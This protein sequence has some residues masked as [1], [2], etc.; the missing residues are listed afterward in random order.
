MTPKPKGFFSLPRELRDEIYD[1]LHRHELEVKLE[2]VALRF[3]HSPA[4]LRRISRRFATECALRIPATGPTHLTVSLTHRIREAYFDSDPQPNRL[5]TIAT[6]RQDALFRELEFEVDV[7][8]CYEPYYGEIPRIECCSFWIQEFIR[9]EPQLLAPEDGGKINIRLCFNYLANLRLI[10]RQVSYTDWFFDQCTTIDIVLNDKERL[11]SVV[12]RLGFHIYSEES[13]MV[14]SWSRD[15]NWNIDMEALK[16]SRAE[17]EL[18]Q[19][20][21]ATDAESKA[22][23]VDWALLEDGNYDGMQGSGWDIDELTADQSR[24]EWTGGGEGSFADDGVQ[25]KSTWEVDDY[26]IESSGSR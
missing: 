4:H 5:S 13:R 7:Q 6:L 12:K 14:A 2:P 1:I 15:T 10:T 24:A 16:H 9:N 26:A 3:R 11:P 18:N 23:E 25:E 21:F 20:L 19:D 17:V 22:L 8:D